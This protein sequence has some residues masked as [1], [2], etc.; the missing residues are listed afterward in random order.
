M[1]NTKHDIM[2]SL[3]RGQ[4]TTGTSGTP[5]HAEEEERA[6]LPIHVLDLMPRQGASV[7]NE[8]VCQI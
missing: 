7:M 5:G 4:T 3:E 1:E 8:L 6:G 2:E